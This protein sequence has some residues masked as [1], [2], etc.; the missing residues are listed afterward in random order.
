MTIALFA[1]SEL[2]SAGVAKVNVAL[3]PAAS[4]MVPEFNARDVVAT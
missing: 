3:L 4:L 2:A 1:P